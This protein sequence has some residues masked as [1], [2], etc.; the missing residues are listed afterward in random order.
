MKIIS[1]KVTVITF[2]SP[3][4]GCAVTAPTHSQISPA[5]TQGWPH[6]PTPDG[7]P[8]HPITAVCYTDLSH[9]DA[10]FRVRFVHMAL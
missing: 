7:S 5:A 3:R 6:T 1:L 2:A 10:S 9:Y 4:E 8:F